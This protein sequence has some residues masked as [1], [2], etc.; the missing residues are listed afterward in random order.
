[1]TKDNPGMEALVRVLPLSLGAS[2]YYMLKGMQPLL[3][4]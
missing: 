1:M 4:M 2:D 3:F